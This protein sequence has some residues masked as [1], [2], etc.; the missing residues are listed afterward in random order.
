MLILSQTYL[1]PND[2]SNLN[3]I[4]KNKD[5]LNQSQ[6]ANEFGFDTS[7]YPLLNYHTIRSLSGQ[8]N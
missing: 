4:Q 3:S 1:K 5:K 6:L 7:V 2:K 8:R